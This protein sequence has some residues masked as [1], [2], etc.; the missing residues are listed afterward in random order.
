[1]QTWNFGLQRE[2]K[3]FLI[4]ANYVGTKGTHLYFGGAGALNY[5]GPWVET[6]S[7]SQITQLNSFIANPFYGYITN[8]ASAL[9][10]KTVQQYQL[11]LPYPSI[12]RL[13][14]TGS[15]HG[16]FH[17]PLSAD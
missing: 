13:Q 15:A 3:G 6:L 4:D 14:R 11:M 7:A 16:G 1:M 2:L 9:S 5:L 8:P 12:H 10:N 17:L